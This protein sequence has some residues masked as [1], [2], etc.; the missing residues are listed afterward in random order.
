MRPPPL[1]A[2][3]LR[4][5]V[6][7]FFAL[8]AAHGKKGQGKQ[9]VG[10]SGSGSG[11]GSGPAKKQAHSDSDSDSDSGTDETSGGAFV[12]AEVYG[13]EHL[14][15]AFV[16]LPHILGGGGGGPAGG[17]GGSGGGGGDNGEGDGEGGA[18]LELMQRGSRMFL[19]FL[20]KHADELLPEPEAQHA[21]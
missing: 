14:L 7:Q 16:R 6:N 18:E 11:S 20:Q 12:P 8:K 5:C 3:S 1:C 10:G 2:P 15:R 4:A 19:R 9:K 17:G 13:A 21:C